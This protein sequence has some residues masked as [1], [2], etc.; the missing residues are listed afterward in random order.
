MNEDCK[1]R[2]IVFSFGYHVLISLSNL[3]PHVYT[4]NL[5]LGGEHE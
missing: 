1:K 5:Y 4:Q 3:K 2:R